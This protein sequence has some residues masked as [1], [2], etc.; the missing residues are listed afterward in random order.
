MSITGGIKFFDTSK[1]LATVGGSALTGSSPSAAQ[2]I[3]DRNPYTV[4]RSVGSNDSTSELITITFPS[5]TFSRIFL[6]G[7]NFKQFTVKYGPSGYS[8]DFANVTGLDATGLSGISETAFADNVAYYEFNAVTTTGIRITPTKTQVADQDK[9]ISQV[10]ITNELGT[11]T[12]FPV[13]DAV[14]AS[15]NLRV[16]EMLSGRKN[17]VKSIEALSFHMALDPY[18]ASYSSDLNL[19]LSLH[20]REDPFLS[21][22]CGGRRSTSQFGYKIRG[23]RLQDVIPCQISE[24]VEQSYLKNM[25]VGPVQ[26]GFN[27]EEVTL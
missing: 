14:R 15:R 9:Y 26:M 17:I 19:L 27:F 21:W 25:Y 13:I 3:I 1:C 2:Y 12:G 6:I 10:I 4:W 11:L 22:L 23:F 24:V 16:Q 8:T 20:D 18:P 7:H 5:T